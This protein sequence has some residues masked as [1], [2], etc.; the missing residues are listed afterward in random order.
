MSA[1]DTMLRSLI[2]EKVRSC[3]D[4]DLLDLIYKLLLNES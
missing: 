1:I 3:K 2:I 4:G